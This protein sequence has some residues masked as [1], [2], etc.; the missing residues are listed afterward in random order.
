[1]NFL[2]IPRRGIQP[3][4]WFLPTLFLVSC[5]SIPINRLLV[6]HHV[7]SAYVIAVACLI[8]L[9]PTATDFLCV[10]DVVRYLAW[11]CTGCVMCMEWQS[12]SLFC[13]RNMLCWLC[14]PAAMT[15]VALL[16]RSSRASIMVCSLLALLLTV[17]FCIKAEPFSIKIHLSRYIF[18]IYVL[19]LPIQNAV[20]IVMMKLHIHTN[21]SVAIIF[22]TGVIIP[23]IFTKAVNTGALKYNLQKITKLVGL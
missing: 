11:F 23:V 3:H 1:M 4:L 15:V 7:P 21:I 13:R 12:N 5:I 22:L 8:Q 18:P 17:F 10:H 9:L 6:R 16:M 2:L 14:L 19:S 20:G